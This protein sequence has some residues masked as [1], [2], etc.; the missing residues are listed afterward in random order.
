MN[1]SILKAFKNSFNKRYST[2]YDFN[3]NDPFQKTF[4][5]PLKF[6]EI[7]VCKNYKKQSLKTFKYTCRL[8]K[9]EAN[10]IFMNKTFNIFHEHIVAKS[11][12]L[13]QSNVTYKLF[14]DWVTFKRPTLYEYI[15]LKEQKAVSSHFSILSLVPMLLEIKDYSKVL[16][17]GTGSGSMTLFLSEK[18]NHNGQLHTFDITDTKVQSAKEYFIDWKQSYDLSAR[19]DLEKWPQ[20]VKFGQMNFTTH[21]FDPKFNEYYDSIY[22]DMADTNLALLNAYKLLRKDGVLVINALHLTQV[23]KCL[24]TIKEF[25]LKLENELVLEP[26]NR[27]WELRRIHEQSGDYDPLKWT[28]RLEDRFVEKFKRGGTWFNYWSGF[29]IKFRKVK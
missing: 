3:F 12:I 1:K 24:N 10:K 29:L 23:I 22:L 14:S 4:Q 2:N 5:K 21:E 6:N 19:N 17:C 7:L 27:F 25:D 28:C 8:I 11:E 13:N 9:L 18:L 26:S 15:Q 16:E 20:N